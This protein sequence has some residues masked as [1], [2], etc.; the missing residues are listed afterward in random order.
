MTN[1]YCSVF[2]RCLICLVVCSMTCC[3][4]AAGI[5]PATTM[6][7][8]RATAAKTT[9]TATADQP[10]TVL[11]LSSEFQW[12]DATQPPRRPIP[13][14][15]LSHVEYPAYHAVEWQVKLNPPA[16][17]ASQRIDD[18]RSA[19]FE[20]SFPEYTSVR[21]HWNK[22]S[23]SEAS[24]FQPLDQ[25]IANDETTTLESIGGRSSDGVMPYFNLAG[26]AG[27]IVV[28]IGWPGDWRATFRRSDSGG[29]RI[30]AGLKHSAIVANNRAAWRLPS[31]L[32]MSYQGN[33]LVG[34][35]Q[36]RRLMLQ[37]FTPTNHAPM[38]L[39]PVAASVHGMV[40]FNDTTEVNLSSLAHDIASLKLPLDTFWLDAGW[41][42]G[43]FPAGQ[44]NPQ[45]D[46]IRFPQGLAPIGQIVR[47][48]DLRFLVWYEP[49]R[50]MR[51]TQLFR[52]HQPWLLK[53]TGTTEEFRYLENDGFHL[54][55]LGDE[56]VRNWV[57][58]TVSKHIQETGVGI[59]R[60]D[61]NLSPGFFWHTDVDAEHAAM[62]EVQ[63]INGLY[64]YLDDLL[65]RH[66]KL[67]IDNCAAG[68]RR[69]D[70][71]M[72]RRS[73]VLWRSDSCWGDE[74]YPR[75]VQCMTH[76]LSLWLPLHGLGAA[77][78]D[79]TALKSGMGA[80]ASFA[81]NYRDPQA[82]NSLRQHLAQYLPIR[83]LFTK[84]FYPLTPWTTDP[85]AWLAF[86]F[87]D[88]IQQ[89]GFIQAFRS[90]ATDGDSLQLKLQGLNPGELYLVR[91]WNNP[92][93]PQEMRGEDMMQTGLELNN[94]GHHG[95][96][97]LQYAVNKTDR[98]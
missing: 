14:L 27:G 5:L 36:F 97:V 49:E 91:D 40:G 59:Y 7:A 87:H 95:T 50:V 15:S 24:D 71:E 48:H 57:T 9:A 16:N 70:F 67:I 79:E 21:L 55:N 45:A 73:V 35:N 52:E 92:Q 75:N 96:V 3:S 30:T 33:W 89:T 42:A 90:S 20:V 13:Q 86:Q 98:H 31:I 56:T 26:E 65:Q 93:H 25:V 74:T 54:L 22:G 41:N 19:D 10:G 43:G 37:H 58:S 81:I 12:K 29:V 51:G 28:A 1:A 61:A 47:S 34:Q 82:V 80:C 38:N 63:Y 39:M 2:V 23:H 78:A 69:L 85:E 84:D 8:V 53:P 83:H 17:G 60:Q 94:P 44:G 4:L 64:Q 18:I 11:Q 32:L 6:C 76:G 66:P 72:M 77:A 88:P 62:R 68:G 46:P